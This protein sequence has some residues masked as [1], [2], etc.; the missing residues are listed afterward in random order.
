MH[1][2]DMT[3]RAA[4]VALGAAGLPLLG[5]AGRRVDR[6]APRFAAGSA[7]PAVV[8]SVP[9]VRRYYI[10]AETVRWD[11]TPQG[12]D[13][14]TGG[15]FTA[16]EQ[17]FTC[18]GPG[19]LGSVYLK[20]QYRRYADPCFTTP[21]PRPARE[22]YQGILGP[23][24][25]AR[26]GDTI[27]VVFR[28]DTPFPASMHPHGVFY[29][30][31]SEG[32]MPDDGTSGTDTDGVV[33]PGG[34]HTYTWRVP[35]RSGPGPD[36]PSSVV[37]LYHDHSVGMGVP[38]TQAGL[39]GP[40][41]ISRREQ[42]TPDARPVDVDREM[43]TLFTSFDENHSPY[44]ARNVARF[45]GDADLD[46]TDPGFQQANRKASI[47]GYLFGNGPDGTTVSHPALRV[48]LGERVRWYVFGLGGTGDLHTPHWHGNTVR[49]AGRRTDVVELL[50]ASM[51]T[52]D[53]RPDDPGIWLL[54]CHVDEHMMAGMVTRYQAG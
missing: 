24:I 47:N 11:Y 46:T 52:A 38:G 41:V 12:H 2:G 27:Q 17:E 13:L 43:F 34:T 44:L 22:A 5:G 15:P 54:H 4:L 35:D 36:D 19:R 29:T 33:A 9:V 25:R 30:K 7:R 10:A 14:V 6:A 26:V 37:W 51:V 45:G 16:H 1:S 18:P 49:V 3:R 21:L 20:S 31:A 42:S 48:G 32:A 8:P 28:N 53:M 40:I 50:P 23:V 39:V